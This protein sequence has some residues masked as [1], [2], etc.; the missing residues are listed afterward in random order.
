LFS[1]TLLLLI[2]HP[3]LPKLC[4]WIIEIGVMRQD[5]TDI[6]DLIP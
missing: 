6:V 1:L 3:L 4:N 5:V 2:L